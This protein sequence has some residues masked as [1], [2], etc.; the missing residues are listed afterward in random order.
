MEKWEYKI[1]SLP[2]KG[3][4]DISLDQEKVS[5]LLNQLG[6]E[7]WELVTLISDTGT[8]WAAGSKKKQCIF[9]RKVSENK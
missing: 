4:I 3:I 6:E 7:G 1:I 9:K 2:V 8:S 5:S